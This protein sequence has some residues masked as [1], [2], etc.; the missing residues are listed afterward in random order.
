M[1]HIK[2]VSA[3]MICTIARDGDER[4]WRVCAICAH[5]DEISTAM[6]TRATALEHCDACD[7][8]EIERMQLAGIKTDAQCWNQENPRGL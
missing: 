2:I 5:V 4:R 3:T 6:L 8:E 1:S 7:E